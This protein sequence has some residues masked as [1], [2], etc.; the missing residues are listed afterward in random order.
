MSEYSLEG[1]ILEST[2]SKL[3]LTNLVK[4]KTESVSELYIK[5]RRIKFLRSHHLRRISLNV[6]TLISNILRE[7][8]LSY[9]VFDFIMHIIFYHPTI[10]IR[11]YV[12]FANKN[13]SNMVIK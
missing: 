4:Q 10:N 2:T 9:A 5:V 8:S 12:R 7:S 3:T 13:G 1:I 6:L 11:W